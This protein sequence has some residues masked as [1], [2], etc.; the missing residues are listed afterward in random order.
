MDDFSGGAGTTVEAYEL[1]LKAH[2]YM[3]DGGFNL[4]KWQSNDRQLLELIQSNEKSSSEN[5]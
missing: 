5:Q 2:K 1:Y 3:L 4:R